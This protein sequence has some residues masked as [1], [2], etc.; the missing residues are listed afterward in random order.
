MPNEKING[1]GKSVV[2]VIMNGIENRKEAM[3]DEQICCKK[4]TNR[5]KHQGADALD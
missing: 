1:Y 2:S 4:H 3:Q 5:T